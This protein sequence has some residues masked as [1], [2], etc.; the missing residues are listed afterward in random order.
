[1]EMQLSIDSSNSDD[2]TC[3]MFYKLFP[4]GTVQIDKTVYLSKEEF[5]LL[6]KFFDK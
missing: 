4:D 1:M 6:K 2:F 5:N 3:L